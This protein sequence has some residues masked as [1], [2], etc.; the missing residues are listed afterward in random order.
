MSRSKILVCS[1][2]T[3]LFLSLP[4]VSVCAGEPDL[5]GDW[6]GVL[7]V[8][9]G[10]LRLAVHLSREGDAWRG[11]LDSPDQGA[12]GL[13]LKDIE[14]KGDRLSFGLVA[15]PA[16]FEGVHDAATDTIKGH[17]IQGGRLPLTLARGVVK[18]RA[19]PQEPKEAKGERPYDEE[20][21]VYSHDPEAGLEASFRLGG[22]GPVSLSGT[23]TMPK[24]SGA[25]FPAVILVSGSGPQDRDETIADH[26]PFLVLADRLTRQG[27][28]VLRYDDRGVGSSTG[29][30][31]QATSF[32]FVRDCRAGLRYLRSRRDIDPRRLVVAGHS[33]G[34]LIAPLVAEREPG[35]AGIIL[36]AG[37]AVNGREILLYQGRKIREAMGMPAESVKL[38]GDFQEKLLQIASGNAPREVKARELEALVSARLDTLPKAVRERAGRQLRAQTRQLLTP[39]FQAF[40]GHDPA[41]PLK[42]VR[43]P[44]LALFGGKDLQ[45]HPDQNLVPMV[46]ALDAGPCED[47]SVLRLEG[48]NHLFQPAS[49]G[50]PLEYAQIKTTMTPRVFRLMATW[51]RGLPAGPEVARPDPRRP[52]LY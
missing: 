39:W 35:L 4:A 33:E 14:V 15:V 13:G 46:Q 19:R 32:D 29:E 38:E 49:T 8:P 10:T 5:A 22:G 52:R 40:L 1:V 47:F 24:D 3:L 31:G 43:C 23:L 45:V 20:E 7:E 11:T 51:L 6:Q 44:V 37:P 48:L 26:K 9:G 34:G 41:A 16:R 36:L 17:W 27:F 18:R 21:V 12:S 28:A 30:F 25:P 42:R 50:A 2:L